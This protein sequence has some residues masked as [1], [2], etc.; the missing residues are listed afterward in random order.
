MKTILVVWT[1][2]VAGLGCLQGDVSQVGTLPEGPLMRA[3]VNFSSFARTYRTQQRS[4][5]CWAASIANIFAFHG[6]PVAQEKIVEAVYGRKDNLPAFTGAVI[7][8]QVNRIWTDDNGDRFRATLTAAYDQDAGVFAINNAFMIN[9][10]RSE[11]P[12]LVGNASHCMVATAIDFSPVR[13]VAVGVFDPWPTA[14]SR[15]LSAAE[16]MPMNRGGQL[17]FLATLT[18]TDVR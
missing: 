18:V 8:R 5:W 1:I 11:R 3:Q 13:V 6:H 7:A 16:M 17:R 9:E 2:L 10:L 4:Q 15:P 14:G 12:F